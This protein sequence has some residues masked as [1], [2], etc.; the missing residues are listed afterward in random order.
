MRSA[1]EIRA[2][3]LEEL[4]S[5]LTRPSMWGTRVLYE[6][7]VRGVLHDLAFIDAREAELER[8]IDDL[9]D[10]RLHT[11]TGVQGVLER[12]GD[13]ECS[14]T[15]RTASVYARVAARLDYYQ[16][17]RRLTTREWASARRES[18]AWARRS[19]RSRA[20]V[21]ARFGQPSFKGAGQWPSV[22]AYAGPTDDVWLYFNFENRV[23]SPRLEIVRLPRRPFPRSV[24][25]LRAATSGRALR[26][27]GRAP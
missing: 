15:D 22:L 21:E 7:A 12:Y 26:P 9:R 16:P 13:D 14:V 8:E 25:D 19:P 5:I 23:E 27:R 20:D 17:A 10:Q 3:K 4:T 1:Q 2:A 24:I 11:S 18:A 6:A